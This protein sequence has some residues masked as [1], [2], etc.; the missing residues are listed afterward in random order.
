M[1]RRTSVKLARSAVLVAGAVALVS[2]C[3]ARRPVA[4]MARAEQAVQ[5]AQTTSEADRLAPI[6]LSSAQAKL[7]SARR[8][9]DARDYEDARRLAEEALADAQLAEA[10]AEST[11]A[12]EQAARTRQDIQALQTEAL[13][14]STVVVERQEVIQRT[15]PTTLVVER[16]A[17]PAPPP[18]TV[19]V[20]RPAPPPASVVIQH[21]PQVVVVPE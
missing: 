7:A 19:V 15:P 9:M 3:A 16:P 2:A 10:K 8:A 21:E 14:P 17:P 13:S 12:R 1:D 6:E 4:E 18:T 20:E 5:H 11:V